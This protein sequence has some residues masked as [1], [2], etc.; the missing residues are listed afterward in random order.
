MI[1]RVSWRML[2]RFGFSVAVCWVILACQYD[3]AGP[4][5]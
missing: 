2:S 1:G 3:Y 5:R 4:I